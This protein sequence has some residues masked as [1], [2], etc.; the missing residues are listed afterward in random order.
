MADDRPKAVNV[1]KL[2]PQP[3]LLQHVAM[4]TGRLATWTFGKPTDCVFEVDT[5]SPDEAEVLRA[6]REAGAR[7]P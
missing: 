4:A 7:R 5:L 1:P 2:K 6:R 3:T